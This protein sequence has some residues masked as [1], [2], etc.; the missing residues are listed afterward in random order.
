LSHHKRFYTP[1]PLS[2]KNEILIEGEE[3]LHC[4]KVLRIKEGEEV[5]IINGRGEEVSGLIEKAEKEK[6]FVR[7]TKEIKIHQE[8]TSKI[9]LLIGMSEIDSLEEAL[10]HTTELGVWKFCPVYTKYSVTKPEL[11]ERKM[12][13]LK[14]IAVSGIKQSGF[15]FLPEIVV[16]KDLESALRKLPREGFLFA[17]EAE[18]FLHQFGA[19]P[20]ET[21]FAVGP[22]GDFSEEEKALFM[23]CGFRKAKLSDNTLRVETASVAALATAAVRF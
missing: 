9:F 20:F 22:E 10:L 8:P 17:Q 6:L 7:F 23:E 4:H 13:R 15:P 18:K 2:G 19:L 3:A 21:T 14:K 1:L 12:E 5:V 11:V 16:F